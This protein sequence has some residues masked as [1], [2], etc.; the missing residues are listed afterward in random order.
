MKKLVLTLTTLALAG[1]AVQNVQAGDREWATAG[2]ILTGVFAGS[3]LTRAFEP[4]PVYTYQTATYVTP[5]VCAP[6]PVV[7][8]SVPVYVHPAPVYVQPAPVWV[9]PAPVYV[10][11]APVFVYSQPVYVRPAPVISFRFGYGGGHHHR[12]HSRW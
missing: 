5:T 10:Q 2:K 4:A 7:V 1:T 3:V 9:Q 12:H 11:P 6:A 8:Q